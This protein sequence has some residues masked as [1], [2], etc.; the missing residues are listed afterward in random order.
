MIQLANLYSQKVHSHAE[1]STILKH[2]LRLEYIDFS[3]NKNNFSA[4]FT[5]SHIFVGIRNA[6]LH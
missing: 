3:Y 1:L 4:M 2:L 5:V 6:A